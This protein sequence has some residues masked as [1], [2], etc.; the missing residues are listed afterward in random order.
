M[1]N[2][3]KFLALVLATLM[4]LSM[5]VI[6]SAADTDNEA[7][8]TITASA[9]HL[10]A[11]GI[12]K[13]DGNSLNLEGGVTRY[14]AALF[15][16][17]AMTGKTDTS[18]WNADKSVYFS[19]VPEYGTAV[20][21]AYGLN[22]IAGRGNGIF[23]YNGSI[24]YQDL[25]AMAVRA[26]GYATEDTMYPQ[27]YILAAQK[28]E[29]TKYID[30]SVGFKDE[31][32]RGETAQI[33]WKML[34]TQIAINDPLTGA[35]IYPGNTGLTED[36]FDKDF[37][38]QRTTL[39]I[40]AGFADDKI[41]TYVAQFI[42]A[43]DDKDDD[44]EEDTVV[45]GNNEYILEA[46][47]L[48][49]TAETKKSSYLGLPITLYINC[50][51][52][53]FQEEYDDGDANV[54]FTSGNEYTVVENLG[55]EGK[56]KVVVN[57]S[58]MDKTYVS[59]N[60]TKFV[61][62]KYYVEVNTWDD[63]FG[64]GL[65]TDSEVADA[66]ASFLYSNKAYVGAED[67]YYV[68]NW[69][70]NVNALNTYGKVAYCVTDEVVAVDA[71]T[72]ELAEEGDEVVEKIL[73][74]VLYTPYKFGQYNV[75]TLKDAT[76]SKDADYATY[77]DGFGTATYLFGT[78]KRVYE[79]TASVSKSNGT[80]AKTLVV[81]GEDIESGDFMFYDYKEADN[82]LTVVKNCG[83]F[84][85]GRL[86]GH[87]SNKET[88]KI[89][90]VN[91]KF[92]FDGL[93]SATNLSYDDVSATLESQ[94]IN[95]LEKGKNNVKYLSVD[96]KIVYIGEPD[97]DGV[98]TGAF[99]F[100]IA[101]TD[102]SVMYDLLEM[103]DEDAYTNALT[104]DAVYVDDDGYVAIAVLDTATGEWK[105]AS[106]KTLAVSYDATKE[107]F[108]DAV[109]VATYAEFNE[110]GTLNNTNGAQTKYNKAVAAL[111]TN[112][113]ALISEDDG[114][115]KL[116]TVGATLPVLVDEK[117][118]S[119]SKPAGYD[120]MTDDEIAANEAAT[121]YKTY[122]ENLETYNDTVA[123]YE[124]DYAAYVAAAYAPFATAP[125]D[126]GI[127]FSTAGRTNYLYIPGTEE[128]VVD[129]EGAVTGVTYD[130]S[131]FTTN[132]STVIVVV[133]GDGSVAVRKGVTASKT[134]DYTVAAGI[135]TV[136]AASENLIVLATNNY[137]VT[138]KAMTTRA[139]GEELDVWG[140]V[141][142][143]V[144]TQYYISL[145]STGVET[146]V[147]DDGEKEYTISDIWSV[148]EQKL[149]DLVTTSSSLANHAKTAGN[150]LQLS[151]KDVLS[152]YTTKSW[153]GASIS[154]LL[155]AWKFG[156]STPIAH[157]FGTAP[158]KG[159][160][161][162]TATVSSAVDSTITFEDAETI[163][164]VIGTTTKWSSKYATALTGYALNLNLSSVD[165]EEYDFS[166]M[167]LATAVGTP[168]KVA[169][170]SVDYKYYADFADYG[171]DF[172]DAETVE[173]VDYYYVTFPY[174]EEINNDFSEPTEGVYNQFMI[175]KS[176]TYLLVPEMDADDGDYTGAATVKYFNPMVA[177]GSTGLSSRVTLKMVV[178][179][180][181]VN[182]TV[183]A[184]K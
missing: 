30:S 139:L 15:F 77:T 161:T 177:Y 99:E 97:E 137:A 169:D 60:G 150:M 134:F 143:A 112:I 64:W 174:S 19:D 1:R 100:V 70:A 152:T 81:E 151:A 66:F 76:T 102:A 171:V 72:G 175:D 37:S 54:V 50:D 153:G 43:D 131:R 147:N 48:G 5:A 180:Q 122:L 142:V 135:N 155:T 108:N 172:I 85:N 128:D 94:Y 118:T 114:V 38:S 51:A 65:A 78:D 8:Y 109:D 119:V 13:G 14:Q 183:T 82:V 173:G 141:N 74:E 111:S 29:L 21:Y 146:N 101:T 61:N 110:I 34:N 31:L 92:G 154:T 3:K 28:L 12:L 156:T 127:T 158:N 83:T 105:L 41:E 9:S 47:D 39:L 53:K 95:K 69:G 176:G 4:V 144:T 18:I 170:N 164:I 22:V 56:I 79:T 88:V 49:I 165:P 133:C 16:V 36:L 75:L 33:I 55:D 116:G 136:L 59:L 86:T 52:E 184:A 140:N 167:I 166:R 44:Y 58:N 103:E 138:T 160:A 2:L 89:G 149:V 182:A 84:A 73:V 120:S 98:A 80:L 130:S 67:N 63:E 121:A 20:D 106:L 145:P 87:S 24:I 178:A 27:G 35:P 6:T 123:E 117:P 181:L 148:K 125:N 162:K 132:D 107:E 23:D 7:D 45:L 113:F 115:Y 71:A 90:G 42:A 91:Y 168:L 25:L 157:F 11:L 62:S 46:A 26:L 57:E 104:D 124:E 40:E 32:T 10:A 96:G 17:Q 93:F 129:D 159:S 179:N 126:N 163:E 68:E